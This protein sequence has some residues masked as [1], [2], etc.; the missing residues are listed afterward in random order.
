MTSDKAS[1]NNLAS[2]NKRSLR[3]PAPQ[4][5]SATT[6]WLL[7]MILALVGAMQLSR[8]VQVQSS[9]GDSPLLSANDRSR[10]CTIAALAVNGSYEIDDILEIRDP[11]TRRR[12]WY[13]IDLVQHRGADGRQHFYSSKPPLLPTLY[14][15]IYWGLRSLTGA[16]LMGEPFVV[17]RT[18]LALVNL[19][20]L[21]LFWWLWLRWLENEQLGVWTTLTLACF[22]VFGTYLTTFVNT[23]NNHLPA[24]I[25]VGISLWCLHKIAIQGERRWLWFCLC[26]LTTSFGAANELPALSWV[27]AAG[28]ML[29]FVDW[30]KT[31]LGYAPA[32][33]PVAIAFFAT[34]FAAH[35]ELV[36][37]YGHR[38]LGPR[39]GTL[40]IEASPNLLELELSQVRQE[41]ST[42][43][44][45]CS[46]SAVLRKA[47]RPEVFEL[48]DP[49]TQVRLGLKR[50]E[51]GSAIGVYEWDDWYDYPG[52]YWTNDRKQGVD[53][54]EPNQAKYVFHSLLGHHGIFSLTPFWLLAV[55]GFLAICRIRPEVGFF[56]NYQLLLAGAIVATSLVSIG[57]YLTRPLEDR[58][59]GGVSSGF[60]WAFWLIPLWFWLAVAQL[61]T[62]STPSK[63]M[64]VIGLLAISVFSASFAWRNPWTSPWIMQLGQY[65]GWWSY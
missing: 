52:S 30:R 32:L 37:A 55:G 61:R 1:P 25:A 19:L 4:S 36:P 42:L 48:W 11:Q 27:A 54:G 14:S 3:P 20:P 56:K 38:S 28:A 53:R 62:I 41:L 63:R 16:T 49:L 39:I 2:P 18:M 44:L 10:W 9:T 33:L 60:R 47:R 5:D 21:M 8:I 65:C 23:L 34:N 13:T 15:G 40:A 58:N 24:A 31:L 43:E 57:F 7:I 22:L 17:V 64:L 51:A 26:G 45:P 46:S 12:N 6:R 59:Y 50:D 29:L 35:G